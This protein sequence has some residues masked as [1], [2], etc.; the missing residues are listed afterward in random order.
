MLEQDVLRVHDAAADQG[1]P[2]VMVHLVRHRVGERDEGSQ[3]HDWVARVRAG[4]QGV[5]PD[6][7]GG[8]VLGRDDGGQ[9]QHVFGG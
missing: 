9:L 1:A 8:K 3:R 7:G 5:G 4:A 6:D 2:A